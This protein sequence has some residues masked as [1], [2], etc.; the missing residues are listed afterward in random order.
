MTDTLSLV[1]N[2]FYFQL[3]GDNAHFLKTH[4]TGVISHGT[5]LALCILDLLRWPQEANPTT[6]GLLSTFWHIIRVVTIFYTVSIRI[7]AMTYEISTP[8]MLMKACT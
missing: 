3:E 5:G 1:D 8:F 2:K 7:K 4:L 6:N